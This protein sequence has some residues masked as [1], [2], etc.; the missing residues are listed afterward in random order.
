[1]ALTT[2]G[3]SKR[4]QEKPSIAPGIFFLKYQLKNERIVNSAA[5]EAQLQRLKKFAR[6][7]KMSLIGHLRIA[8]DLAA[9]T[10]G[11]KLLSNGQKTCA[12]VL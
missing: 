5:Q 7:L 10:D 11:R 9:G 12:T 3:S 6:I 1:M 2:E 4:V 8:H